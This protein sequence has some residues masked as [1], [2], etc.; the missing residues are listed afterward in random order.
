MKPKSASKIRK[1]KIIA[2]I[3]P[4]SRSRTVLRRMI[5]AGMDIARLNM[6]HGSHE[7]HREAIEHVRQLSQELGRPVAVLLD[8]QGP[9]IRTGR[10]TGGNPIRLKRNGRIRITT[11]EV[12]GCCEEVSTTYPHLA[13]DVDTGGT[14]LLSDGRI[15]LKVVSKSPDS[16][17]CRV[18]TGGTLG[19]NAGINLP[20]CAISAPCLTAKDKRDLMFGT[21]AG[22]DY[23]ALSFVRSAQD[24][25]LVKSELNR[26]GCQIPVIAKIEKREAVDRLPDILKICD[27]VMVA[28]G[29]LGAELRL[30]QV[31]TVQKLLIAQAVRANK[32]AITATQMLESMCG[33]PTPTRAEVSDVAN[34]IIDGTDAVMLS[35][36]TANGGYPVEAIRAMALIVAET[37]KSPFVKYNLQHER[38]SEELITHAAAQSAANVLHE[39]R[40]K[41]IVSFSV[42]G[43][44]AKLISK[45]RPCRPIFAFTPSP[46]VYRQMALLWGTVPFCIP[47]MA[48]TPQLIAASEAVL[49]EKGLI[50]PNDIVVIVTG[51]ALTSGSTN[52]IKIHRVG[53]ED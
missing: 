52:M 33:S 26:Y 44:S 25:E 11:R 21:A 31:P 20:E 39:V 13:Q 49:L 10:L 47:K 27:G 15:K 5:E 48:D 16:V 30:E 53:Q 2:T 50:A 46:E 42:S 17:E 36:E 43:R 51:L 45:Q 12:A 1:T 4:A 8:L 34:A 37:E 35:G 3:G 29:D 22:V 32:P 24:I 28:R 38:S 23:L 9:K 18:V 19:E 40:A 14:L 41:A 7:E 6:S